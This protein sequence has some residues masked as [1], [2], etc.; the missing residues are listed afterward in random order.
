[1]NLNV[2]IQIRQMDRTRHR[3]LESSQ[4][5]W[6]RMQNRR[7][8]VK[9]TMQSL[10]DLIIFFFNNNNNYKKMGEISPQKN[11]PTKESNRVNKATQKK[12]ASE[13]F[14][15]EYECLSTTGIRNEWNQSKKEIDNINERKRKLVAPTNQQEI[16]ATRKLKV[17]VRRIGGHRLDG[18]ERNVKDERRRKT[19]KGK[20]SNLTKVVLDV[21]EGIRVIA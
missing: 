21:G 3:R 12:E 17:Q 13:K 18:K 15:K 7:N 19:T 14:S 2:W 20:T 10:V 1:M 6:T 5:H 11:K 8:R 9:N 16:K 4:Y